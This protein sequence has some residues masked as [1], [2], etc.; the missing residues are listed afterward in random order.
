VPVDVVVVI[1]TYNN[2]GEIGRLMETLG[3][4][5]GDL[6]AEVVVVDN[7]STDQTVQRLAEYQDVRVIASTN[8]GYA[9]AIN[10]A[11]ELAQKQK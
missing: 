8:V 1:V 2:E 9:A 5:L 6:T 7:G 3:A 4:G 10:L 11:V